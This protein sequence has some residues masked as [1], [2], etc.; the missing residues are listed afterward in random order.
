MLTRVLSGIN[1]YKVE[2]FKPTTASQALSHQR[3]QQQRHHPHQQSAP[4]SP[5]A[6][7]IATPGL[8]T[9]CDDHANTATSLRTSANIRKE[10]SMA[11]SPAPSQMPVQLPT[12]ENTMT[13]ANTNQCYLTVVSFLL[14]TKNMNSP[15][16]LSPKQDENPK[17]YSP[18]RWATGRE[19]MKCGYSS[20]T[21]ASQPNSSTWY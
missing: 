10:S 11:P 19:Q 13:V 6:A 5:L 18:C 17:K 9:D 4:T 15:L 16:I 21:F 3:L 12:A 7:T 20:T 1:F 14:S 8:D 2:F